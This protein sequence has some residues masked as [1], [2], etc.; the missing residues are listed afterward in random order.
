MPVRRVADLPTWLLGRAHLR[1]QAILQ[2]AFAEAGVRGYHYRLLAALDEHGSV[3]QTDLARETGIDRSDVVAALT[4]LDEWGLTR[5]RIDP[6]DRRRNVVS[7]TSA[8]TARLAELDEV[9]GSVQAEVLAPLDERE[10][11]TLLRLLAKV[12][13]QPQV[14]LSTASTTG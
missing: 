8:G 1:A 11:K 3:S 10:R 5:R 4:E 6:A 2:A 13:A 12:A 14:D 9:V 7:L